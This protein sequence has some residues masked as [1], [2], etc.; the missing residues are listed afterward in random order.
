[1]HG[2]GNDFMV[3]DATTQ[4]FSP[5][6]RQIALWADR[7]WGVGF[8]QLLLVEASK[9]DDCDFGYR[10]FNADGSEAE[11]CGNGARCIMK[12]LLDTGLSKNMEV[13]VQT[14]QGKIVLKA[15]DNGHYEVNM[16]FPKFQCDEIP[17]LPSDDKDAHSLSH[18]LVVG[19]TSLPTTCVNVGNPHA[20]IMVENL[21]QTPVELWGSALE[22][23]E[24]FPERTNVGFMQILSR[25]HIRL[26]VYERGVG[27]TMACGS[28]ACAAAVAGIMHQLLDETVTVSQA[29]GDLTVSWSEGRE[30]LMSGPAATV[31]RGEI[32]CP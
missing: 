14:A 18:I 11:Q 32:T 16:G 17:Y 2:L 24:Q 28:G 10:I 7:H 26:R 22:Q 3:I 12:F 5:D 1:M 6:C 30:I 25:N 9:Q 27:E 29:G 23:H 8:D 13:P 31:Y 4:S 15:L 20:V 21:D 19:T